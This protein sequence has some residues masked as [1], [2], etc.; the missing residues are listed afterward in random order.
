MTELA[1]MVTKSAYIQE[2]EYEV[3]GK[4]RKQMEDTNGF[5]KGA[6]IPQQCLLGIR[7]FLNYIV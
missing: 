4:T 5:S 1:A 7:G 3:A 6:K 2:Q